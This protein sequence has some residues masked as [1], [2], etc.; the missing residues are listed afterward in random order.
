[1]SAY[2][3]SGDKMFLQKATEVADKLIPAWNTPSGVPHNVINLATGQ[4]HNYDWA[5]GSI[6]ADIGTE[7]LEFIALSERTNNKKY[8]Q[9]V[10]SKDFS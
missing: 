8:Q 10:K 5:Q 4:S 7:Q 2:D 6:L 1:M 9:K 3:L